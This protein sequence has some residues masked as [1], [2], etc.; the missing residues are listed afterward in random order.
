MDSDGLGCLGL[1]IFA[2][3]LV[4]TVRGC[5]TDK[6][7]HYLKIEKEVTKQWEI[8]LQLE[9]LKADKRLKTVE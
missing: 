2:C 9:K 6:R 7:S 3:I 8:K 1:V 5:E 4:I